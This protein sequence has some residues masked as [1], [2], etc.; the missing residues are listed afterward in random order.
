M[1]ASTWLDERGQP[2]Q[3]AV[4]RCGR[5]IPVVTLLPALDPALLAS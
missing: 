3:A 1:V 4:P 5:E 2:V